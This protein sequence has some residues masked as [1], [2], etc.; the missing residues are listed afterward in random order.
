IFE[1]FTTASP[2]LLRAFIRENPHADMPESGRSQPSIIAL[3]NRLI[4]WTMNEHPVPSVRGAL[5]VPHIE[6]VPE[7]Y[8]SVNP[9]D[10]PEA[11][12]F[13]SKK[14]TPEEELEA[15]VES[16]KSHLDSVADLPHEEQPTIAILV[17]RNAR[18]IEVINALKKRGVETI[19]LISSTSTTR[20][21]AGSLNYLLSYLADPQSASK[22]SKAYQVWRRDI[23]GT[24]RTVGIGLAP[25][26]SE[27][28]SAGEEQGDRKGRPYA[29]RAAGLLRKIGRVEDY[30]SPALTALTPS[31]LSQKRERGANA[32][33]EINALDWLATL[34]ESEAEHVI[35]E[36][37]DFRVYV[38]RWLNA[39]TLPID[40]L[41]LT[42][43]QDVFSEASDLALANK[44]AL[45]L[46]QAANS[47]ADWRLPELS[48]ELAVIA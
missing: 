28:E 15:V 37:K 19:E 4:D 39:V 33:G 1:T 6:P 44:L 29:E 12:R 5:D 17:P 18:G 24:N 9:P 27:E 30:V 46:R 40:Q 42:L 3:A 23:F 38:Q 8:E 35:Q 14:Y 26:Q 10:N 34:G 21:A 20:A 41:T 2:E 32:R 22:L 7:G 47:H 43:A 36:L 45:V 13:I 48:S 11:I 31:P 25:V 16:V